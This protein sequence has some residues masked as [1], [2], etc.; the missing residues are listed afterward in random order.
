[1]KHHFMDLN[2]DIKVII[3]MNGF[4]WVY[5]STVKVESDYF[6]EDISKIQ[7]KDINEVY[8]YKINYSIPITR[9]IYFY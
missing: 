7:S 4:I 8:I 6:T 3:G 1:M 9:L 5:F 2:D